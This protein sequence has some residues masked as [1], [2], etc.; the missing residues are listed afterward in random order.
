[1]I[2]EEFIST[3]IEKLDKLLEGGTP[4][5]YTVL[6][7]G[8]PGSSIEILSKQLAIN[9]KTLYF[10]TDETEEEIKNTMQRFGWIKNNIEVIDIASQ[11]SESLLS[12]E[13]KRVDAYEQR[14]KLRLKELIEI[15]SSDMQV[16][17]KNE[18]DFLAVLSNK[19]KTT[20]KQKIIINSLDFFLNQYSQDEVIRT[21]HAAKICNIKNNGVLYI[22]MTSGIHGDIFERRMEGLVD[23]ILELELIQK[24]TT[25]E[26]FLAVKKMKNYAKKVGIARYTVDADGFV[27]EMIERI[28]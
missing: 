8:N 24:G 14:S 10:T 12:G 6:I 28:M 2:K 13:Q 16:I 15:G 27:L 21:I 18:E 5:G 1:M 7:L 11:F 3:G 4:K 17:T 19:I 20:E 25:F 9:G 26:R 23:C 22:I